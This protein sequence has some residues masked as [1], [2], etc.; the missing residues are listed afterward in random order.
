AQREIHQDNV[1]RFVDGALQRLHAVCRLDD[2][3]AGKLQI[4]AVHLPGIRVIVDQQY[5]WAISLRFHHLRPWVGSVNVN[6][7][8]VPT[9][10][11]TEMR[12][13]S[14]CASLRHIDK[15]SP[16]PPYARVGELSS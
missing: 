9:A 12:P 10:L 16:V 11:C 3:E 13:S 1:G 14:I 8:P 5:S 15:P 4:F 7:R 2:L 6:A